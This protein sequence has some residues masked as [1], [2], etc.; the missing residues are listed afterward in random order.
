MALFAAL[1]LSAPARNRRVAG[2]C[3]PLEQWWWGWGRGPVDL[4][5][6]LAREANIDFCEICPRAKHLTRGTFR[7]GTNERRQSGPGR[8]CDWSARGGV[9]NGSRKAAR[10]L[11]GTDAPVQQTFPTFHFQR[12]GIH[13]LVGCEDA[14]HTDQHADPAG[15]YA[16]GAPARVSWLVIYFKETRAPSSDSPERRAEKRRGT[17]PLDG[18]GARGPLPVCAP[19]PTQ[20]QRRLA[21][22]LALISP[23]V[24]LS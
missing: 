10:W 8:R 19:K 20:P 24:T 13:L 17:A 11:T 22:M 21:R 3:T 18:A 4:H 6:L 5:C 16:A 14:L 7:T 12:V 9:S 2:F 15:A 1:H 23:L